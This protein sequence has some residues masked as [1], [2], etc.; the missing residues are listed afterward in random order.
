MSRDT[1]TTLRPHRAPIPCDPSPCLSSPHH[2][3]SASA[4]A[5]MSSSYRAPVVPPWPLFIT[6]AATATST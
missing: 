3:I 5:T 2:G 4:R 1:Q 6:R